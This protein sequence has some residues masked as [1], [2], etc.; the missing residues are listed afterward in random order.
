MN[1][2]KFKL[3]KLALS[4]IHIDGKVTSEEESWFYETVDSLEKNKILNFSKEQIEE[5]KQTL[6]SPVVKFEE[7]FRKLS[8]PADCAFLLH[9][10]RI[11]SHLD[12]DFSEDE[13][14]M[15]DKLEKACLENVNIEVTKAKVLEMETESYHEKNVYAVSNSSSIFESTFKFIFKVLNPGD[16]KFPK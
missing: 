11:S 15:Y 3:W 9:I 10:L 2:E 13:R 4:T 8:S 6:N 14:A 1:K 7:E 12:N 16:Y 5:L